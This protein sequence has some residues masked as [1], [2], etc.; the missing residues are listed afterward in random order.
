MVR[1]NFYKK[2]HWYIT[3]IICFVLIVIGTKFTGNIFLPRWL[4]VLLAF[5]LWGSQML[6]VYLCESDTKKRKEEYMAGWK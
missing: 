4:Y 2:Q 1:G 5:L 6:L 3:G